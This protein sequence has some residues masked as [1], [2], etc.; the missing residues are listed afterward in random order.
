MAVNVN[1][2][3]FERRLAVVQQLLDGRGLQVGDQ[4]R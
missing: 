1:Q 4:C 3:G 2:A